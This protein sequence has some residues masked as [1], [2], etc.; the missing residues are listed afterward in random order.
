VILFVRPPTGMRGVY[1]VQEI[2]MNW[3]TRFVKRLNVDVAL[4]RAFLADPIATL[5]REGITV[6]AA[7][8]RRLAGL[9]RKQ[10]NQSTDEAGPALGVITSQRAAPPRRIE[11]CDNPP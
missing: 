9:L 11:T 4:R 7:V 6:D 1:A 2:D 10:S 5:S 3:K 8:A